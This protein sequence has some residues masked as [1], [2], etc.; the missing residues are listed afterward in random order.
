[1]TET[2]SRTTGLGPEGLTPPQAVEA[3]RAVLAAMLLDHEAVGVAM[4]QIDGSVFDRTAHQKSIE[5]IGALFNR[6]E[7]ADLV[8]LAEELR[9]RGELEAVGGPA[10]LTQ[11]LEYATAASNLEQHI[12]IVHSKSILR[13][14]IKATSE[15]QQEAYAGSDDT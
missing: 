1:M 11:V 3:E 9:K 6:S 13:Q 4:E 5:A 2:M 15:I 8:T 12:K 14:L 10:A 7:K